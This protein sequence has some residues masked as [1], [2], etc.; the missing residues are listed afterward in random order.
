MGHLIVCAGE[1]IRE[2]YKDFFLKKFLMSG[3]EMEFA[4][5]KRRHSVA[6]HTN[7]FHTN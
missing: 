4:K 5:Q 1:N 2:L 6:C 3:S 7:P